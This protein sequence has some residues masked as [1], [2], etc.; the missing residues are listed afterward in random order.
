MFFP[1]NTITSFRTKLATPIEL[2]PD[3]WEAQLVEISYP[4]GYRK[5]L[6]Y[7]TLRLDS[8]Q[9][10]FPI[11]HYEPLYDLIA[12]LPQFFESSKKEKYISIF[13]EYLKKYISHDGMSKELLHPCYGGNSLKIKEEVVSSFPIRVY[14]GLEDLAEKVMNPANCHSSR[15]TMSVKDNCD[16]AN[17]EPVYVYTDTINLLKYIENCVCV[18][19]LASNGPSIR[20]AAVWIEK[21]VEELLPDARRYK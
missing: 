7:N 18:C 9:I 21:T 16:F 11:K 6:L 13:S 19:I 1:N 8:T 17:P 5:L 20:L 14:K 12:N 3:K 15:V 2:E 4:R 10:K